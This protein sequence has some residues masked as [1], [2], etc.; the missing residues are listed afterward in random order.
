MQTTKLPRATCDEI[1]RIS[2]R[3]LWGGSEDRRKMHLV[4]WDIVTKP[5][6]LGGLGIRS[7][8]QANAAFL[9]KLGW[10]VLAEPE[11]LWSRVLRHK[12]CEGRCDVEMFQSKTDASNAWR[13][14]T[15]NIDI[16]KRG[17]S[18][19]V[20]NGQNTLFWRQPWAINVPLIE[21]ATQLPPAECLDV[22]VQD[23]WDS[24]SG[25]RTECFADYLPA[26]VLKVIDSFELQDDPEAIDRIY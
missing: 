4:S 2:R 1:D 18:P 14:I 24:H 3:F 25:W 21:R 6:N 10:R 7:M 9:T 22:K 13:G 12:Y 5:K 11:A 26:T 19:A 16:L 23:M 17:M 20:G 15:D 8:R